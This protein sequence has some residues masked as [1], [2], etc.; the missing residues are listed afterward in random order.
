MLTPPCMNMKKICITTRNFWRV[1]NPNLESFRNQIA[2]G[3]GTNRDGHFP[4]AS[5]IPSIYK[6][7]I[8]GIKNL[9]DIK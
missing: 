7:G 1:V 5:N 6:S 4:Q 9:F 8:R 3:G 2:H